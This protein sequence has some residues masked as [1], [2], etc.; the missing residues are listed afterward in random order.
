MVFEYGFDMLGLDEIRV[1]TMEANAAMRGIMGRKFGFDKIANLA[2]SD[3]APVSPGA[4]GDYESVGDAPLGRMKRYW[5][6]RVRL[7]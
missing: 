6:S 4:G 2:K 5:D 3:V 7:G 1:R